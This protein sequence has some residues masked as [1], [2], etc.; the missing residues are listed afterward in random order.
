MERRTTKGKSDGVERDYGLLEPETAGECCVM[1][2]DITG[3]CAPRPLYGSNTGGTQLVAWG[4]GSI[5]WLKTAVLTTFMPVGYPQSVAREYATYQAWDTLQ[6]LCSYLRGIVATT[7][8]LGGL[9]VGSAEATPLAAAVQWVLRDGAGMLG[10]LLFASGC[11]SLFDRDLKRWRLFADAINDLGLTLDMLAPLAGP[12][13]F[14]CVISI[15]GVCKSM[16]GVAAGAT[17]AAITAHFALRDNM[18]DLQCKE[19]SQETLVTLIGLVAGIYTAHLFDSSQ[20]WL[21]FLLLTA[22]HIYANWMGVCCLEL[23]TLNQCRTKILLER[24]QA[25]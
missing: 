12:E 10:G 11:A 3:R 24:W 6:A 13:Y 8:M 17:K 1:E 4:G 15:A 9:G 2:V 19:G 7:Q 25:C 23:K 18:G 21:W 14:L 22:L 16:C 20:M 5:I